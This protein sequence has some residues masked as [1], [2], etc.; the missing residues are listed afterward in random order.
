MHGKARRPEVF[1]PVL[2]DDMVG[3]LA[4]RLG[5]SW[6]F[7]YDAV[8]STDDESGYRLGGEHFVIGE[9]VSIA[10]EHGQM[11]TYRVVSVKPL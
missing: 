7:D 10:G 3:Q 1:V 8:D 6:Y 9:Y 11:H 2:G 4:R 5:G